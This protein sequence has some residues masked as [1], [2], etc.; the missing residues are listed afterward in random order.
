MRSS[1]LN[2]L[3]QNDTNDTPE[4][5][6]IREEILPSQNTANDP[7]FSTQGARE[8]VMSMKRRKPRI[9]FYRCESSPTKLECNRTSLGIYLQC[10]S[11]I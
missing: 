9:S 5:A 6:T 3:L 2:T 4:Q 1:V 7:I 10:L 11:E 8:V